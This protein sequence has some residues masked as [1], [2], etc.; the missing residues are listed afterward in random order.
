M[1]YAALTL[2][3]SVFVAAA[4]ASAASTVPLKSFEP[5]DPLREFDL[6]APLRP[7]RQGSGELPTRTE[8]HRLASFMRQC[9]SYLVLLST[10]HAFI[11]VCSYAA[12]PLRER[13]VTQDFTIVISFTGL[14]PATYQAAFASAAQTW[15]ALLPGF[16]PGIVPRPL[17]INAS[18]PYIDG[19][20][21]V[22]G[23]SGPTRVRF[24]TAASGQVVALASAGRMQFDSADAANLHAKGTLDD[25]I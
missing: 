2:A 4:A 8:A 21:G 11:L 25:V 10:M 22:L 16:L 20:G 18:F 9:V 15:Q 3:F 6:V 17:A 5:S 14:V 13:R 12:D 23:Q 24:G 19:K 7:I 1:R